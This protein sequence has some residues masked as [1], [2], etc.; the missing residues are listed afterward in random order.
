MD[1]TP[2]GEPIGQPEEATIIR[3]SPIAQPASSRRWLWILASL[4]IAVLVVAAFVGLGVWFIIERNSPGQN[5]LY[6]N[7][8]ANDQNPVN[9]QKA[10]L[11]DPPN[12]D[13][14]VN[15]SV[16]LPIDK[17]PTRVNFHR[18]SVEE[19]VTG[20]V[21]VGRTYLFRT[22]RG[23]YLSASVSSDNDCVLFPNSLTIVRME[24]NEG[25]T[26][27]TLLN[28]CKT[29]ADFSMTVSIR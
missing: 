1:G 22:R 19:T 2:L 16:P 7:R 11:S 4:V 12:K 29:A 14:S 13:P 27:M 21:S 20:S 24:T 3:S 28:N 5:I 9:Q 23:Q 25:D 10:N 18:G 17:P 15:K 8:S 26:G 6:G